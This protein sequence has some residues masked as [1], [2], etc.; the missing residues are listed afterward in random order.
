MLPGLV[1]TLVL[2]LITAGLVGVAQHTYRSTQPRDTSYLP[3]DGAYARVDLNG[4]EGQ[5]EQAV[6]PG[7]AV[8]DYGT[9]GDTLVEG[10][11]AEQFMINNDLWVA[12]AKTDA[13]RLRLLFE[14]GRDSVGLVG[15][16][17]DS[18]TVAFKPSLPVS[19]GR[20]HRTRTLRA[21]GRMFAAGLRSAGDYTADIR[22]TGSGD[23]L[24]WNAQVSVSTYLSFRIRSCPG[25]G[26][27]DF[28]FQRGSGS[29]TELHTISARPA[30]DRFDGQLGSPS[31]TR[32]QV[33]RWRP[34]ELDLR[35]RE[36]TA[37][38]PWLGQPRLPPVP[39]G[40][41]QV[42]IAGYDDA[43]TAFFVGPTHPVTGRLDAGTATVGWVGFPGGKISQLLSADQLLVAITDQRKLVAYDVIG[44]RIWQRQLDDLVADATITGQR[45]VLTIF[46]GR[47]LCIDLRTGR[48]I[49]R[50]DVD[51]VRSAGLAANAQIVAFGD[52]NTSIKVLDAGSG[53]PISAGAGSGLQGVG[54]VGRDVV[55]LRQQ[56]FSRDKITGGPIYHLD[57]AL[58][59]S[60]RLVN[61]S[62]AAVISGDRGTV[63]IDLGSG[64]IIRREAAAATIAT[65]AGSIITAGSDQVTVHTADDLGGRAFGIGPAAGTE[66]AGIGSWAAAVVRG[67][68]LVVIG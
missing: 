68:S 35:Q 33:A 11:D 37:T 55:E 3:T 18:E 57:T 45:L 46:S 30:A 24:E 61:T 2:V 51:S 22:A 12:E 48:T 38:L 23:C 54:V 16:I 56:R 58:G 1:P 64:R 19:N 60:T 41:Q 42:A 6:E 67:S 27:Q 8:V 49:W 13:G 50:R 66:L 14:V 20:E 36:A 53:R 32:D 65:G 15:M 39:F 10:A 17:N 9:L 28:R 40:D 59:G 4:S 44:R 29:V 21:S 7:S 52:A 25:A 31:L 43:I 47:V 63:V 34:A 5:L 26:L 62:A